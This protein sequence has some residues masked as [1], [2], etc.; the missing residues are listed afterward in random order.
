MKKFLM[1]ILIAVFMYCYIGAGF[2]AD[3]VVVIP[4]NSQVLCSD[5]EL[6]LRDS[7]MSNCVAWGVPCENC[8]G[9]AS[10]IANSLKS[11]G[12]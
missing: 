3:K 11:D 6:T 9:V 10:D 8:F 7:C 1:V 2:C 4:L 5:M 12:L